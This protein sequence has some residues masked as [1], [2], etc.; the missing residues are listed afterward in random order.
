MTSVITFNGL[1]ETN[2]TL[3]CQCVRVCARA[4]FHKRVTIYVVYVRPDAAEEA[5]LFASYN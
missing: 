4:I 3:A 2:S 1:D 5:V